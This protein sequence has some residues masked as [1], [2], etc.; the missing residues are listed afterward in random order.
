M[1]TNTAYGFSE[2][3]IWLLQH[4]YDQQIGEVVGEWGRN[5]NF[6][7]TAGVKQGCVLSPRLFSATLEWALRSWKNAS[8]G[9]G[10]DLGDGLPN[11]MEPRFADDI[12]LFANPG[13]E[14]AQLLDKLITAIGRAGLI[15]NAEKNGSV[16][17]PSTTA[18]NTCDKGWCCGQGTRSQSRT[19][20]AR[21]H[22]NSCWEY[23]TERRSS[24]PHTA[25]HKMFPQQPLDI[26]KSEHFS[27]FEV[28]V[29][30]AVSQSDLH[31]RGQ[32]IWAQVI[33]ENLPHMYKT[34]Q[35]PKATSDSQCRSLSTFAEL[36][37]ALGEV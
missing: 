14:A 32:P 8:Q 13:P 37:E 18:S 23:G 36:N 2:H 29:S 1:F 24:L 12:L 26:T 22:V 25:R 27:A 7:I 34:L 6:A 35:T 4:I 30:Q 19:K 9:A 20:M 16:Y 28:E 21:M 31:A 17:Q 33:I 3:C 5:R 15:L 10:I 11:L